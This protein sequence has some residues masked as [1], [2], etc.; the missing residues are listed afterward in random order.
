MA[1]LIEVQ[2]KPAR[3]RRSI[4]QAAIHLYREIGHRKTTV[5]DIAR[6]ASMSSANVYRFFACKQAVEDAVVAELLEDIAIAATKA[7][8]TG[9]SALSRLQATL[10]AIAEVNQARRAKDPKLHELMVVAVRQNWPAVVRHTDRIRGLVRP[11]I[12]TGEA[13]GELASG[14]PMVLTCCLLD[15]MDAYLSPPRLDE[16]GI[17]PSFEE[18]MHFCADALRRAPTAPSVSTMPDVRLRAVGE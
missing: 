14:S 15:A 12:G 8:R 16:T 1:E 3:T 18:M 11:I 9:G 7:A 2:S 4:V 6:S 10:G 13:S 5:A 17:R